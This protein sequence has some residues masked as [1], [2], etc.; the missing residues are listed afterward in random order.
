MLGTVILLLTLIFIVLIYWETQSCAS[1]H[2]SLGNPNIEPWCDHGVHYPLPESY[3]KRSAA[4]SLYFKRQALLAYGRELIN[5]VEFL[6]SKLDEPSKQRMLHLGIRSLT[7]A[8]GSENEF[9]YS[10]FEDSDDEFSPLI[11]H[12][13]TLLHAK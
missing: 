11:Q 9:D 13:S 2:H 3:T 5:G 6:E 1:A 8:G 7:A 10:A 4:P 12:V